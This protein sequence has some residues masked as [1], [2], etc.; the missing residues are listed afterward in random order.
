MF[1]AKLRFIYLYINL[2][3][4]FVL[5]CDDFWFLI[6]VCN[7][8][9]ASHAAQTKSDTILIN[10]VITLFLTSQ[11]LVSVLYALAVTH[12]RLLGL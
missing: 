11:F 4:I 7:L 8:F 10:L 5:K 1:D 6:E 3:T 9:N 2:V 12:P